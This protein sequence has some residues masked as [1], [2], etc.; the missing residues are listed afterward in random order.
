MSNVV[1]C[2]LADSSDLLCAEDQQ[3]SGDAIRSGQC[4]V[5]EEATC[6]GPAFLAVDGAPR[7]GPAN[8]AVDQS[9]GMAVLYGPADEVAGLVA[10]GEGGVGHPAFEVGLRAGAQGESFG[11]EPGEEVVGRADVAAHV[12]VL[13]LGGVLVADAPAESAQVVPDRVAVQDPAFCVVR[14]SLDCFS[15]PFLQL[16]EPFVARRQGARGDEDAAKVGQ[17]LARREFIEVLVGDGTFVAPYAFQ[18]VP[19]L[20]SGDPGQGDVGTLGTRQCRMEGCEFGPD[21]RGAVAEEVANLLVEDTSLAGTRAELPG[22]RAGRGSGP[23]SRG[24]GWCTSRTTAPPSFRRGPG[25]WRR[26][27]CRPSI[28]AGSG[29]TRVARWPGRARKGRCGRRVRTL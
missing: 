18:Q 26:S 13:E 8:G 25:R 14:V 17:H 3:Q 9:V 27:Y 16:D 7:A 15:D 23:R 24:R 28:A 12:H 22:G 4:V 11:R 6:V 20:F 1:D 5:V 29:R 21:G 10:V 19:G 2:E